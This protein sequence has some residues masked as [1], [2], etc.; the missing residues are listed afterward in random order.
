M[1][2][3]LGRACLAVAGCLSLVAPLLGAETVRLTDEQIVRQLL[4]EE[5]FGIAR[6]R[7]A[8]LGKASS[9]LAQSYLGN[10]RQGNA[11]LSLADAAARNTND[12]RL[13]KY[14]DRRRTMRDDFRGNVA[15]ADWCRNEGLADQ[16][17]AHL[18]RAL[19]FEP[20]NADLRQRL[21]H[22]QVGGQWLSPEE[23]ID[24]QRQQSEQA[25][26]TAEWTPIIARIKQRLEGPSPGARKK[27]AGELAE[28]T[29]PLA[30]PALEAAFAPA[31]DRS[32]LLLLETLA[33][34]SDPRASQSLSRLAVMSHVAQVREKAA[35]KL[36]DRDPHSFV[37]QLL[38]AMRGPVQS[39]VSLTVEPDG[40]LL[41]RHEF[42]RETQEHNEVAVL[43]T[44]VPT[45]PRF[46]GSGGMSPD[47]LRRMQRTALERE[48]FAQWQSL[49]DAQLNQ[50]IAA[51][52]AAATDQ[53]SLATP[54][55]WWQWWN[56]HNEAFTVGEKGNRI[57]FRW[58]NVSIER[59]TPQIP[60]APPQGVQSRPLRAR[61]EC[62]VAGT[63]VFTAQGQKPI[64]TM[65]VGDLVLAQ[66]VASGQL[67]F[68]PVIRPTQ[69]P[70]MQ[71]V[72]L[73]IGDE[74]LECTGGH[75][76]WVIGEGWVKARDLKGGMVVHG[77]EGTSLV[78][79]CEPGIVAP[80]F[81]LVV[82]DWHN[83][84]VG[85]SKC[86]THDNTPRSASVYVAPGVRKEE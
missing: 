68:K 80:T 19:D 64:E 13:L 32:T 50:R 38:A 71:L 33:A 78:K 41:Y 10:V 30:I 17:A 60:A 83:Y 67:G 53:Q 18:L 76:F 56:A 70:A 40:R 34:M 4:H 69:R 45:P 39:R 75:L 43:D 62:F 22:T 65:Q 16:E 36:R 11:W 44:R 49:S 66:D 5:A 59:P 58:Q 81:N 27:A 63:L 29:D 42:T 1:K 20:D 86:L 54:E 26:A 8:L 85:E 61:N 23:F 28:V 77:A 6:E 52:L 55:E 37:P 15:I 47:T 3:L 73:A 57:A 25:A 12:S 79:S 74:T 72:S 46:A 48:W 84:F 9:P 24:L 82:A 51:A 14:D 21:K 35:R 7:A 31:G 2:K